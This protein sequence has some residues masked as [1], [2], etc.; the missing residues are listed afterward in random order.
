MPIVVIPGGSALSAHQSAKILNQLQHIYKNCHAVRARYLHFVATTGKLKNNQQKILNQL[1]HYGEHYDQY[2]HVKTSQATTIY[3]DTAPNIFTRLITPRIGTISPWSSKATDILHHCGLGGDQSDTQNKNGVVKRVERGIEWRIHFRNELPADADDLIAPIIHDPMTE[4]VLLNRAAARAL[5]NTATPAPVATVDILSGG[6]AALEAADVEFGF[7]LSAAERQYLC[8]Q[9]TRLRRNPTDAEL[10]MFAQVNSEHCRHKIFNAEWRIDGKLAP[11]SP[12]DMIR[13]THRLHGIGTLIAY[14]DNA[15]VIAGREA[16]RLSVNPHTHEFTHHREAAHYIAKVETHNHPTAISPHAGAATGSG[17]EIRD[18]GATG[19]GGQPKAG[20]SGYSVS[21][22]RLPGAKKSWEGAEN[23][24]SRI[25]A[26][27][28]IMLEAPIGAAAF[29]NEFGRPNI[30]GYFRTFEQVASVG[31]GDGN[32]DGDGTLRYGYHKP[33][34]LAGGVGNIRPQLVRKKSIPD[35]AFI[36]ALGGPVMLIGL[37]G[38]AASSVASGSRSESLDFASVQRGNPEM[39]RRCQEVINACCALGMDSP[40]LSI[41][42]VGAGGFCNALPELVHDSA[43]GGAFELRAILNAQAGMSPMQIWCNESQERY[44]VAINRAQ[45]VQ[46]EKICQRERCLYAN[47]GCALDDANGVQNI[48]VHDNYFADKNAPFDAPM[49]MSMTMPINVPMDVLFGLPPKMQRDVTTLPKLLTPLR[50][51]GVSVARAAELVLSFPA[52]ADKTFLVTIGDRSVGGLIARDQMVGQWQVPVADVGVAASGF[53]DHCGEAIALGERTPLAMIDAAAAARMAVGEAITNIAAASIAAI[54][55]IKLSANWMAAA[56]EPGHDA[57]LFAAVKAVAMELCPQLGIS[58]PVGKDSMSMKTVWRDRD[59]R[60]CKAVSPVSLVVTAF[61]TVDDIRNTQTPQ[62]HVRNQKNAAQNDLWLLDLGQGRNRLGGSSL[63]Q[64]LS[65]MGDCAPDVSDANLLKEFVGFIQSLIQ[66]Q[67]ILAYHDRSDGGL[68]TTLCEMAFASRCG[69]AIDLGELSTDKLAVLFNEE[70]GAVIQSKTSERDLIRAQINT[71]GLN[72]IAHLIGHATDDDEIEIKSAGDTWLRMERVALHRIWSET[73][74]RMQSL[75]DNPECANQE[76][77]RINDLSDRGLFS[78]PTFDH[79]T[80]IAAP[81]LG[82]NRPKIAILR[83]QGVN[84]QV[85]MAAAFDSAGFTAVDVTMSDLSAGNS[86]EAYKGFAACGGFSFGDVLGAGQGW[87][88]SI[89]YNARL[90]DMFAEFFYREDTFA[91]GVCNGCQMMA[92]IAELIP[93]ASHWPR[94]VRNHSEQF[95]ARVAML[96][97]CSDK[98]ILLRAMQGSMLPVSTTHGEGRAVFA[99]V[100][101]LAQLESQQ[102]ICM[103]FVDNHGNP[104]TTYPANPNGSPN[105]VTGFTNEDGRFTIM[106]PHPERVF[107][108]TSNSWRPTGADDWGEYSPWIQ[109]FRNARAWVD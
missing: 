109:I 84:G 57:D 50:V 83:E 34:M 95:E 77:A 39:Q 45:F 21:N 65:Q 78:R 24:P 42:D 18:E 56:G 74:W 22:L 100:T 59:N 107:R 49:T 75:R 60:L 15:A 13:E 43:R 63:A 19:R 31:D 73:T 36:I 27:L 54:G 98:S 38:G 30:G 96:E 94:F 6:L 71:F 79:K 35:G 93:G 29:N 5:F 28:R 99:A 64:A 25:A 52:V 88:K 101:D 20:I 8:A 3:D 105:G 11:N 44:V 46:F 26:P 68:L 61:S 14:H 81:Y 76:Y 85:E 80:N 10:M 108:A 51:D 69:L 90:R 41:H 23:K 48:T 67:H 92:T 82:G 16:M 4:S 9:F 40:I 70:L 32:G 86:L 7:A 66:Q 12:F 1:L 58:I 89:L 2:M 33:I 47:L 37:G 53:S 106:M 17:G 97:I 72:A 91:L 55:N 87:A 102:S 62:L 104:T 103:R